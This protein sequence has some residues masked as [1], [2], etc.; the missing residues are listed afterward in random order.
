MALEGG[1][2]GG[3]GAPPP[4]GGGGGGGDVLA[5]MPG[6]ASGPQNQAWLPSGILRL[7]MDTSSRIH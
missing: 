5:A 7:V 1:G 6:Y 2:G 3:G 4:A